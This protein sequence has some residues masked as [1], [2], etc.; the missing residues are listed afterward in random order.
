MCVKV[1]TMTSNE[2]NNQEQNKSFY[3]VKQ[4]ATKT[5]FY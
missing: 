2:I 4:M 5:D 1:I 3:E